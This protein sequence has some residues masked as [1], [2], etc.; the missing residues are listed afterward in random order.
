MSEPVKKPKVE[1]SAGEG[2]PLWVLSFGD[3]ITNLLA[4]VMLL[5]SF[6]SVQHADLL[7]S[8]NDGGKSRSVLAKFGSNQ[9]LLGDRLAVSFD[10]VRTYY[11]VESDPDNTDMGRIID[12]EDE[13]IRKLFDDLRQNTATETS[14][15]G[16]A[17][18]HFFTTPIAFGDG[19]AA[20]DEK[21]REFLR[22]FAGEIA[23]GYTGREFQI[24][25]IGVAAAERGEK[26]QWV[27]SARRAKAAEEFLAGV[28]S[29]ELR[30]F[31]QTSSVAAGPRNNP[32][33]APD[34]RSQGA[35]IVISVTAVKAA[36]GETHG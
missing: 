3:M 30:G 20:L 36:K 23:Q 19:S 4:F 6:S 9:W 24:C 26:D 10:K 2:A 32:P 14:Q 25:V 31:I 28:L 35:S 1:E 27:L 29:P 34:A 16:S 18:P 5:Q 15:A 17:A 8:G 22:T 33:Q 13:K 11:S 21:A 7:Q 12:A